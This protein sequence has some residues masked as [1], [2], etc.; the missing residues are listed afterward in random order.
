MSKHSSPLWHS[1]STRAGCL[2]QML[3]VQILPVPPVKPLFLAV[4][5][6][7][8][9]VSVIQGSWRLI[10]GLQLITVEPISSVVL[11]LLCMCVFIYIA[12]FVFKT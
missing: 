9:F 6:N 10:T 5:N 2:I 8:K 11:I 1:E 4:T 7:D 3:P 12:P